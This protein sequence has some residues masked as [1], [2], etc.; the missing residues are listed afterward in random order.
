M[1]LRI[2]NFI[3]MGVH[4]KIRILVGVTKNQYIGGD[5]LKRGALGQF[6][7]IR[8]GLGEKEGVVLLGG[9]RGVDTPM[10]PMVVDNVMLFIKLFWY[11]EVVVSLLTKY[12][13]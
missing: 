3:I 11:K 10:H 4:S 7:D 5:C 9:G 6:A 8:G 13:L 12:S 2:K 1:R